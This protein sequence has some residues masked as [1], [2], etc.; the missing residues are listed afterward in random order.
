MATKRPTPATAPIFDA[1]REVFGLPTQ[2]TATERGRINAAIKDLYDKYPGLATLKTRPDSHLVESV[3]AEVLRRGKEFKQQ[4]PDPKC[5]TPTGLVG[6]WSRYE[7]VCTPKEILDRMYKDWARD[8]LFVP[9]L[10]DLQYHE[11]ERL[12][13]RV[14][15]NEMW[16]SWPKSLRKRAVKWREEIDYCDD[17]MDRP[18]VQAVLAA[19]EAGEEESDD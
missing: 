13:L 18:H 4:Y 7:H 11:A 1:F 12:F 15:G 17:I 6:N 10:A 14:V 2:L 3:A 16:A 8:N 5:H 9:G 19:L